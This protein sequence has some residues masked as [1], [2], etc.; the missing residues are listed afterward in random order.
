[1]RNICLDFEFVDISMMTIE[2]G[3]VSNTKS[4]ISLIESNEKDSPCFN[5]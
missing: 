5:K 4:I 1:M 3:A 2:K